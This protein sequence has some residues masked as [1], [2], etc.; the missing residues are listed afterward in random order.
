MSL[1][2][3]SGSDHPVEI[4]HKIKL[5]I[6]SA[7][8]SLLTACASLQ[9]DV[10]ATL[11]AGESAELTIGSTAAALPTDAAKAE[12]S[13]MAGELAARRQQ[14]AQA[15]R[16]L[17]D[18]LQ[19]IDNPELARRATGLAMAADDADLILAAAQVWLEQAPN[20]ADPRE[21]IAVVK[22]NQGEITPTLEQLQALVSGNPAGVG[23]GMRHAA[24]LLAQ[25][26]AEQAD[27]ALLVMQNLVA[28]WP[29]E[30]GSY[31]AQGLLGVRYQRYDLAAEAAAKAHEMAPDNRDYGLLQIGIWVKQRE[32]DQADAAMQR[33]LSDDKELA[34]LHMAYARLLL[35]VNNTVLAERELQSVLALKPDDADARFALGLIALNDGKLERASAYFKPLLNSERADDAA[36]QLGRMAETEQHYDEALDYYDR[37]SDGQSVTDAGIRIAV[38]LTQMGRIDEARTQL[39]RLGQRYP[40]LTLRLILTEGELL[41]GAQM[42]DEALTLYSN[43]LSLDPGNGELLYNRSLAYEQ[44]GEIDLA[45]QDLQAILASQPD[46]AHALNALGY[47]LV[48]HTQRYDEAYELLNKALSL[49]PDDAAILDSMAW[50]HFKRGDSNIALPLLEKAFALYPD[51]EVAAHLGEV[52]WSLGREQRARTVWNSAL[53]DHPDHRV[54]QETMQRLS[55]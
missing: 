55:P 12:F 15:A 19:F 4:H 3:L 9:P 5:L 22:L 42:Y 38:V 46:N 51:P 30:P 28:Q 31:Y 52:L 13:I 21:V 26:Q 49:R 24:Q 14:P 50:L 17:L 18:A 45:E 11:P 8:A 27:I 41:A 7:A 33:L 54:L 53:S 36:M 32:F 43:A 10:A 35:D 2:D 16:Y 25:G 1:K 39:H 6:A 29:D 34:A 47:M 48:V 40:Q 23:E 44:K 37:V 20:E